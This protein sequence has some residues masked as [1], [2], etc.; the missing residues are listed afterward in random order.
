MFDVGGVQGLDDAESDYLLPQRVV[1]DASGLTFGD[2]RETINFCYQQ[3]VVE[4]AAA[5]SKTQQQLL[6]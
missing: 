4:E 6:V 2:L 3:R 1:E 5:L